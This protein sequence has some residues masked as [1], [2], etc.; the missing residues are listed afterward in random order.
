M[1]LKLT[2]LGSSSAAPT[3]TRYPSSQILNISERFFLIDCGEGTQMQLRKYRFKFQK[4]NHI[5]IS[6]LHGDHYLGL[7]GLI[8]TMHLLGRKTELHVYGPPE[9]KDIIEM[10]LN[11]SLTSLNYQLEFHSLVSDMPEVIFEDNKLII[12]AF[13]LVHR[14]PTYGFLFKEKK[15]QRNIRKEALLEMNI[16]FAEMDNIKAGADYTDEKGKT[17]KNEQLTYEPPTPLSYA[18]CSD[19]GYTETIIPIIK[20]VD[21]LYHEAT[22]LN[23]REKDAIEKMHSTTIQ[24]A[25]I[26][27]KAN[28]SKLLIGHYSARYDELDPLL[29]EARSVFNETYLAEEGKSF[30]I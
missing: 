5:F 18:Y 15:R 30:E 10:Q 14:I 26:A 27:L 3:S 16:P 21:I 13:S 29:Q 23:E 20:N 19:T 25:T 4:I 7:M 8:F 2:I 22:F 9:L 17:F 11:V 24:A 6:H 1:P 28:V 12:K